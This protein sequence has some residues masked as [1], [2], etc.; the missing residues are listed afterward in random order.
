M[1]RLCS[2]FLRPLRL[3]LTA[4]MH[5]LLL[6]ILLLLALDLTLALIVARISRVGVTVFRIWHGSLLIE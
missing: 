3:T 5:R 4:L 1:R 6:L 2:S